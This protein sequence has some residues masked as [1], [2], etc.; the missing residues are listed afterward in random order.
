MT[1]F[2]LIRHG[3]RESRAEETSLSDVGIKQVEITAKY[4]KNKDIRA[5]YASPVKRTQQT[6]AILAHQLN[7]HVITDDRVKERLNWGDRKGETFDEFLKEWIKTESD[8]NYHPLH[9][10][11]SYSTGN[12]MKAVLDEIAKKNNDTSVLV[13]SHGGAIGDFLRNVLPENILQFTTNPVTETK[14][15]NILECSITIV[16]KDK[17]TYRLKKFNDTS[18]LSTPII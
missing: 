2:Y 7:L 12:R 1:T 3:L 14:Y 10:D 16:Q 11:S 18:H 4:L 15:L 9:G 13:V 8:R 5:I 17:N 6:A